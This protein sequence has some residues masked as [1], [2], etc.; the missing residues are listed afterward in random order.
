MYRAMTVN[1]GDSSPL[2]V[3]GVD[4]E[5]GDW[6]CQATYAPPGVTSLDNTCT[7]WYS[8]Q[9]TV[10]DLFALPSSGNCADVPKGASPKVN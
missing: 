2:Y 7:C 8:N 5:M 6:V 4:G 1:P 3:Q 9:D 10:T